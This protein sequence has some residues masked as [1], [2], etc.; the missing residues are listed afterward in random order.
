VP[1]HCQVDADLVSRS[2]SDVLD[3]TK[4]N[5]FDGSWT[6]FE[7]GLRFTAT[8]NALTPVAGLMSS[9]SNQMYDALI[10]HVGSETANS[11]RIRQVS[12]WGI[13]KGAEVLLDTLRNVVDPA[14]GQ[15]TT[16]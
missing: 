10:H 1:I 13:Q 8:K 14:H 4:Q 11:K 7:S 5:D 15:L 12:Y 3:L 9:I 16:I 6:L 2:L